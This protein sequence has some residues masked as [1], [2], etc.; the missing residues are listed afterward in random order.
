MKHISVIPA[1]MES[2]GLPFKNRMFFDRTADFIE[3]IDW[4]DSTMVSTDDPVLMGKAKER[5]YFVRERPKHLSGPDVSIKAVFDDLVEAVEFAPQDVLWL[6]YIPL[7]YRSKPDFDKARIRIEDKHVKSVCT[8]IAAETHPY[9]CWQYEESSKELSQYVANDNF[10]RQDLP[11]A[12]RH[13][14]HVCC[15]KVDELSSLNSEL[16]NT[17]TAPI[18]LDAKTAENLIEMDTPEDLDRW[19]IRQSEQKK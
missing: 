13:Y 19:K 15:F 10:R 18:F 5:G 3:S 14:H 8:F 12:W 9:N 16:L 1:R 4:F 11:P 17:R 6:F 7:L 2:Q